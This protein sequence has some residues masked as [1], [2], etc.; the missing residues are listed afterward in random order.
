MHVGKS[1]PADYVVHGG[2]GGVYRMKD[3]ELYVIN[4]GKQYRLK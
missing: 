2:P 1:T 4:D 3:V